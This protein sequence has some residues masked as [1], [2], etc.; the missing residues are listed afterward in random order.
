MGL[1]RSEL[2][3]QIQTIA[4]TVRAGNK[5]PQR[6]RPQDLQIHPKYNYQSKPKH[7]HNWLHLRAPWRAVSTEIILISLCN[8]WVPGERAHVDDLYSLLLFQF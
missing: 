3:V 8:L 4:P 5:R 6:S 7:P 2:I 1:A